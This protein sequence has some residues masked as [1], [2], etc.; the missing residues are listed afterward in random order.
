[1]TQTVTARPRSPLTEDDLHLFNEGTHY[2]LYRKLGAHLVDEAE[3]GGAWFAVWAPNAAEVSVI[4]DWNGWDRGRNPLSPRGSSGIWEGYVPEARAGSL[5]KYFIR[6]AATDYRVDK[7]DPFAFRAQL[8]PDT[9]SE[10]ADLRHD[11]QD[12]EWMEHRT[13]RTGLTAPVS[14]YEVHLGSWRRVP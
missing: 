6:S 10:V 8:P 14:I 7:A 13:G 1:M 11:W 2:R 9:A 3:G 4:G 5:Y 12:Q